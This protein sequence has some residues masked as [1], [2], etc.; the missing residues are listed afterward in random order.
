MGMGGFG[1]GMGM[2]SRGFGGMGMGG[3]GTSGMSDYTSDFN[4]F[5]NPAGN[6][7]GGKRMSELSDAERAFLGG[8]RGGQRGF[9]MGMGGRGGMGNMGGMGGG[10]NMRNFRNNAAMQGRKLKVEGLKEEVTDEMI[11]RYFRKFGVVDDWKRD[12]SGTFGHIEFTESYMV[13]Y[14]MKRPSHQ[15]DGTEL[16]VTRAEPEFDEPEE[17]EDVKKED[18]E[19]ME[20]GADDMTEA[21]R[22]FMTGNPEK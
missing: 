9:G 19:G 11:C 5:N 8:G 7:P 22:E 3:M 2:N 14:C 16:I 17:E 13:E 4:G 21:E 10:M 6:M 15:I 1:G 18:N 12:G 20:A